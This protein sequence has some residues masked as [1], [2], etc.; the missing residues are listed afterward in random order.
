MQLFN[1]LQCRQSEYFSSVQMLH[2]KIYKLTYTC[3]IRNE[4]ISQKKKE[5]IHD[6]DGV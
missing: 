6:K 5:Y 2:K 1:T 4:W 3:K